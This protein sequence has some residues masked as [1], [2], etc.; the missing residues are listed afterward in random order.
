MQVVQPISLI[1]FLL[2]ATLQYFHEKN[3]FQLQAPNGPT[4]LVGNATL[5]TI[6]L[7][8]KYVCYYSFGI[9]H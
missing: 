6:L 3:L 9:G 5:V 7:L 4:S 1:K 2:M 8:L